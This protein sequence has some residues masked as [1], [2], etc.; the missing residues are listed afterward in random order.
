MSYG[1][2]PGRGEHGGPGTLVTRTQRGW[3]NAVAANDGGTARFVLGA[4]KSGYGLGTY[5]VDLKS[6]TA[7]AVVNHEGSFAVSDHIGR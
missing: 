7:W 5:G 6:R 4:Y 2:R 1:P 3:I